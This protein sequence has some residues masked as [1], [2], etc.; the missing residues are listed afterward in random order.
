MDGNALN[1]YGESILK[2]DNDEEEETKNAKRMLQW[3]YNRGQR[4]DIRS[5]KMEQNLY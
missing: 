5:V 4:E 1:M 2:G 3:R